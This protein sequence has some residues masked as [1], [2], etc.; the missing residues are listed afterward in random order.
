MARSKRKNYTDKER[1]DCVVF[2][3][4]LGWPEEVGALHRASKHLGVPYNSLR[5][6]AMK[7]HNPPPEDIIAEARVELRTAIENELD[8][9]FKHMNAVRDEASYRDA[10]W[11]AAVLID[12]LQLLTG[13]PT[14]NNDT[15]IRFVWAESSADDRDTNQEAA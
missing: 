5:G 7:K 14:E 9:A 12:K 2:L 3:E 10:A 1:A 8:K 15:T 6:W 13:G 4:S 11:A